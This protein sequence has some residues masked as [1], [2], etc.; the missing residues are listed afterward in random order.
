[1]PVRVRRPR[2]ETTKEGTREQVKGLIPLCGVSLLTG[3][4]K[5]LRSVRSVNKNNEYASDKDPQHAVACEE[6]EGR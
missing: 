2:K 1:M 6:S 3:S 4:V 5:S